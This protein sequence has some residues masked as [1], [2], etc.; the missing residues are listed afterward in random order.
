MIP[1]LTNAR[2]YKSFRMGNYSAALLKK[3][4][5]VGPIKYL[6]V[7]A[8]AKNGD[9]TPCFYVTAEINTMQ[10][11]LMKVASKTNPELAAHLDDIDYDSPFLCT[12]TQSGMHNNIE[13]SSE[14]LNIDKFADEALDIARKNLK[15]KEQAMEVANRK[16]PSASMFGNRRPLILIFLGLILAAMVIF[17]PVEEHVVTGSYDHKFVLT[18]H[19]GYKYILDVGYN[20]NYRRTETINLSLLAIQIAVVVGIGALVLVVIRESDR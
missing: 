15:I 10:R 7:L 11:E 8:V 18:G 5:S 14:W 4:E 6:H 9:D 16:A 17:P 12:F 1:I 19:A 2:I 3:V 20:N 13:Q